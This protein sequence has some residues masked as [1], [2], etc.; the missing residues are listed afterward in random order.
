MQ[1]PAGAQVLRHSIN[2]LRRFDG[3]TDVQLVS[4]TR[5]QVR[6]DRLLR[7]HDVE[8]TVGLKKS[9]IYS[10]MRRGDFPRCV[11][12]SPRCV[13]WPESRILQFVQDRIAEVDGTAKLPAMPTEGQQ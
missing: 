11:Q 6:R 4:E 2:A 5:P 3:V 13:A 9:T 1:V 7:I 8:A 10:L 12:L